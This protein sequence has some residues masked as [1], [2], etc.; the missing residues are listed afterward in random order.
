MARFK[1]TYYADLAQLRVEEL[2]KKQVAMAT[3][4]TPLPSERPAARCDGVEAQVGGDRRCLKPKDSFRDCPNCPEMVVVPSG[5][6][7]MGASENDPKEDDNDPVRVSIAAPF[8]V[9]RF[10]ITLGEFETFVRA[11]G[12]STGNN[13][14]TFGYDKWDAREG[15][16]FRY[17]GVTQTDRHPVVCV[18]W[19]DAKEYA[20]WLALTTHKNYRLL[21]ETEREYVTRAGTTTPFWWG[22]AITPDQAN[23]DTTYGYGGGPKAE[24]RKATVPVDSFA[25]NPWGLYNV[26]GNVW[27]WTED[28][29]NWKNAGNPGNGSARK[30]G[31]CSEHARRGGSWANVPEVLQSARRAGTDT[32]KRV[33]YTGFRLART[34]NP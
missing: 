5:T 18:N 27:E 1:G 29:W 9:G 28:C 25:A 26:H 11:T 13:C 12:Y 15:R 20:T 31:N 2:K 19:N 6:F 33:A 4:P 8:A 21:S 3:P 34:L 30:T 24:W 10:A 7:T 23:Y 22:L 17:P 16:N 14:S 32:S